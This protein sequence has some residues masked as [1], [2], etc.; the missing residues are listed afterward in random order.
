MF[1]LY[2]SFSSGYI[3]AKLNNDDTPLFTGSESDCDMFKS[4]LEKED[5]RHNSV[6]SSIY[7]EMDLRER[8]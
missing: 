1:G 3:V 5:E 4:R 2:D 6:I 7:D 8:T